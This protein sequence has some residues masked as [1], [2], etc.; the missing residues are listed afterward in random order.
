MFLVG[1]QPTKSD[2]PARYGKPNPVA[3]SGT[4]TVS[5]VNTGLGKEPVEAWIQRDD[6]PYGFPRRGR[7][8]YFDH[9]CYERFDHGG[10]LIEDDSKQRPCIIKRAG[11]MNAIATGKETF[12][13]GGFVR[14]SRMPA[15][16]SAG[17]PVAHRCGP[18]VS[19]VS[20]ESRVLRGV[21][22]AGTR[23]GSV[24]ALNGTSVAAPQ[25]TRM[26]ADELA[27]PKPH[28]RPERPEPIEPEEPPAPLERIGEKRVDDQL[29]RP[30]IGRQAVTPPQPTTPRAP[31]R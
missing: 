31:W 25:A 14:K 9:A 20:D 2:A 3:P 4:W 15:E 24:V 7:Q 28:R 5:L 21:L 29:R 27:G 8:S 1:L 12:V 16:Y 10:R 13:V 6:T 22:A 26:E 18:N 30:R 11:S 17:G 23:S 19:A